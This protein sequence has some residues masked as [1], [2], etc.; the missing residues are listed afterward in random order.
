MARLGVSPRLAKAVLVAEGAGVPELGCLVA[1]LLSERDI[2]YRPAQQSST[3]V[4]GAA[5][6]PRLEAVLS[7]R[8]SGA[9]RPASP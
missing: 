3:D 5:L 4:P 2:L 7:R 9:R 6:L 1:A 8:S